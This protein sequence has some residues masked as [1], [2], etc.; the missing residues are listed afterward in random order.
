MKTKRILFLIAGIFNTIVGGGIT[1]LGLLMLLLKRVFR[2][3]LEESYEIVQNYINAMVA[4]DESYAY[5]TEYSKPEAIDYVMGIVNIFCIVVVLFGIINLACGILNLLL[6]K[7][8]CTI[9]NTK[10][11]L[12]VLLVVFSWLLMPLNAFNILTTIAICIKK[13]D[14]KNIPS[15]L[16]SVSDS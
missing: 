10:K 7:R 3:M 6:G 11:Y 5:L 9:L 12:G 4:E 13:K 8:D 14:N 2:T 1:F 16:Y 15:K